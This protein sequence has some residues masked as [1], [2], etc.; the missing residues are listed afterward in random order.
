[1]ATTGKPHT[2]SE[3]LILPPAKDMVNCV[4]DENAAKYLNIV[5]PSNNTKKTM[6]SFKLQIALK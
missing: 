1:V 4:L 2:I 6:F 3:Q 5:L